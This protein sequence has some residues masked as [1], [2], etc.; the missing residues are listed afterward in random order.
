MQQ[1]NKIG[2]EEYERKLDKRI[3]VEKRRQREYEQC[4]RMVADIDSHIHR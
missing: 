2:Y 1:S 4:K 3:T